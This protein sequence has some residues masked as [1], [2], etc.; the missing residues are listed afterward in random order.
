MVI[1][2]FI[3]LMQHVEIPRTFRYWST[4]GHVLEQSRFIIMILRLVANL[5]NMA[6]IE[7]ISFGGPFNAFSG[8]GRLVQHLR[9]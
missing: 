4:Q 9:P 5:K 6:G 2:H 7:N 8:F 3:G 1:E